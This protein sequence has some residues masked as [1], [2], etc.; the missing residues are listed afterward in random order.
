MVE[1]SNNRSVLDLI[2]V[3]YCQMQCTLYHYITVSQIDKSFRIYYSNDNCEKISHI[4][5]LQKENIAS[6]KPNNY[7]NKLDCDK[8]GV[9]W[10]MIIK[11]N[12]WVCEHILISD[13]Y[14]YIR[15]GTGT[16]LTQFPLKWYWCYHRRHTHWLYVGLW[17]NM[18][19]KEYIIQGITLRRTHDLNIYVWAMWHIWFYEQCC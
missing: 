11:K 5:V 9:I 7:L 10:L 6:A 3:F 18:L 4:C 13:R 17:L 12:H 19:T 16:C 1:I 15:Q 2:M 14:I 8:L